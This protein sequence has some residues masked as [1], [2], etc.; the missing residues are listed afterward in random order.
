MKF[1][2]IVAGIALLA[3]SGYMAYSGIVIYIQPTGMVHITDQTS[4][5]MVWLAAFAV[6]SVIPSGREP[7]DG[8]A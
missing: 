5:L 4:L 6:W 3:V 8:E 7:M 2:K 1:L